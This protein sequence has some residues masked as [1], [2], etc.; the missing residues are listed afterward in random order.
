MRAVPR[1]LA[2]DRRKGTSI[3]GKFEVQDG[4]LDTCTVKAVPVGLDDVDNGGT[5]CRV[6]VRADIEVLGKFRKVT[7]TV[8]EMNVGT[9]VDEGFRWVT[10]G[11]AVLLKL[12][13]ALVEIVTVVDRNVAIDRLGAP[14]LGRNFDGEGTGSRAGIRK[15][16]GTRVR[17]QSRH[18]RIGYS[19]SGGVITG[20]VAR[21][22]RRHP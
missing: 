11:S 7:L 22:Q 19:S 9:D 14:Y 12:E 18:S 15:R 20:A 3:D 1:F 10:D 6:D 16:V 21:D 2:A 5:N 4:K 8:P 17:Q 13:D